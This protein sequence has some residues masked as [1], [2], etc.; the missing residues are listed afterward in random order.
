MVIIRKEKEVS[1]YVEL[2]NET[3]VYLDR[4]S[5]T[6]IEHNMLTDINTKILQ[7]KEPFA[8]AIFVNKTYF[9]FSTENR[10][11]I[12]ESVLI[13]RLTRK[14]I[15]TIK[16]AIIGKALD[17]NILC[18]T[19]EVEIENNV[20]T[21]KYYKYLISAEKLNTKLKFD[22]SKKQLAFLNENFC[23]VKDLR[24]LSCFDAK[25]G[26]PI[27][28]ISIEEIYKKLELEIPNHVGKLFK[29]FGWGI[30][31]N[32]LWVPLYSAPK[33]IVFDNSNGRISNVIN[34][35]HPNFNNNTQYYKDKS[36]HHIYSFT[37]NG[38]EVLDL[39]SES[40]TVHQIDYRDDNQRPSG[41]SKTQNGEYYFYITMSNNIVK[42]SK[43]THSIVSEI[44]LESRIYSII[45]GEHFLSAYLQN[46]DVV[47]IR[48]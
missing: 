27:W 11:G 39:L 25:T 10:N 8:S 43:P 22:I 15:K 29:V 3:I 24:Q 48:I 47:L 35:K 18:S 6:L 34:L 46:K 38:I 44:H 37:Y 4:K 40:N 1:H 20:E 41:G 5:N 16:G 21:K 33:Y 36:K 45:A 13:D 12:F 9:L 19:E 32:K 30:Y 23:Y 14:E 7:P 28:N 42:M 17:N 2:S 31:G 26:S